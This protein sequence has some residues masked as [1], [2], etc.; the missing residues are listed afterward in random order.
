MRSFCLIFVTFKMAT[1]FFLSG[2]GKLIAGSSLSRKEHPFSGDNDQKNIDVKKY[3]IFHSLFTYLLCMFTQHSQK[4]VKIHN[5]FQAFLIHKWSVH[6]I[7]VFFI[8]VALQLDIHVMSQFQ[9]GNG[10]FSTMHYQ[11]SLPLFRV[12]CIMIQF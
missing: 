11:T 10:R 6:D 3:S 4:W 12:V 9:V 7:S 8:L 5:N 2:T 1:V